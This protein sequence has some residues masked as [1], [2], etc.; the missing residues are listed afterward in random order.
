MIENKK[1]SIAILTAEFVTEPYFSGGVAQHFFRIAKYL[2]E[3]GHT[4]HVIT[5]SHETARFMYQGLHVYRISVDGAGAL[6]KTMKRLALGKID[7]TIDHL[8][9]SFA[10]LRQLQSIIKKTPVDIIHCFNSHGIG[11]WP[12]LI[13]HIPQL[14]TVSCYRPLWNSLAGVEKTPDVWLDEK[15][16]ALFFILSRH[17]YSPSANLQKILAAELNKK[18][19]PVIRT[20]FYIEVDAEDDSA[21]TTTLG[22]KKYILF[23]GRLQMH[24]GAHILGEALPSTLQSCPDM[25]V[26]FVGLDGKSPSGASMRDHIKKLAAGSANRIVFI[27]AVHHNQLYPILKHARLVVLPSL[28]DN[29]PNT[30]L[31]AMGV[32]KPVIGTTGCSFDEMIEDGVSGFLVQPGNAPALAAAITAAWQ[33]SDA[34]LA[35]IGQRAAKKIEDLA[36]SK[37]V[38]AVIDYYRALIN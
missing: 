27:D 38:G 34:E 13:P 32:G 30:L 20:P 3:Q 21:Y 4:V 26:A 24:K 1:F 8:R 33:C 16:E 14:V 31:E 22:G 35:A 12:L 18:N 25:H 11:L 23:F 19:I 2:A 6:G 5:R 29:L 15:T 9:F 28:I 7:S 37:T 36:P 17:I 10:C